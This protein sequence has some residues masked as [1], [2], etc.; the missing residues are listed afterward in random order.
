MFSSAHDHT[1]P[2]MVIHMERGSMRLAYSCEFVVQVCRCIGSDQWI[3]VDFF[4]QMHYE[5]RSN[6]MW[7][8]TIC[9]F[10]QVFTC[11]CSVFFFGCCVHS[12]IHRM[13]VFSS[14][15]KCNE[16]NGNKTN[17]KCI[18]PIH[19]ASSAQCVWFMSW[20][21]IFG[22]KPNDTI[23]IVIDMSLF[24][25]YWIAVVNEFDVCI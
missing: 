20:A 3:L 9:L 15:S 8:V 21:H 4:H 10:I 14:V 5:Q 7:N 24:L 1:H 13:C 16:M 22:C 12:F 2:Y 17:K 25:T 23:A 19:L 11:C 18:S 6:N